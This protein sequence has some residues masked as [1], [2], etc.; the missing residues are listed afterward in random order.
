MYK[1]N[2]EQLLT[3]SQELG[4]EDI[5]FESILEAVEVDED[6]KLELKETLELA[7]RAG[8]VKMLEAHLDKL[9]ESAE[10]QLATLEEGL[11][12]KFD[13]LL[14]ESV[15]DF[16][17][18]IGDEW[19]EENKVSIQNTAEAQLF[20]NLMEG[21]KGLFMSNNI[22]IPDEKIDLVEELALEEQE[23]RELANKIQEENKALKEE[24]N[25]LKRDNY[26]ATLSEGMTESQRETFTEL[27]KAMKLD[28][29]YESRIQSLSESLVVTKADPSAKETA[30]IESLKTGSKVQTQVADK[31]QESV[32]Q[33]LNEGVEKPQ[34][35]T[36]EQVDRLRQMM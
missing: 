5:G 24:L 17:V 26:I 18:S 34:T 11:E 27:A 25:T 23:T 33:K 32:E 7:S 14:A 28:G 3:E 29:N 6:T 20:G 35:K 2:K 10:A 22:S 15:E 19:L 31:V 21:L 36:A 13:T 30:L 1:F 8:A 12:E 9:V 4:F 16:L